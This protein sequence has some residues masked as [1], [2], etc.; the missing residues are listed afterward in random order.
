LI[1][2]GSHAA[3]VAAD[4][5]DLEQIEAARNRAINPHLRYADAR[6]IGFGLAHVDG[7]AFTG[8]LVHVKRSFE[9]LGTESPGIVGTAT[10]VV[11]RVESV[12]DATLPEPTLT[13]KK[14]FPL[15]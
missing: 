1:R 15:T 7:D 2:Y 5:H 14:P 9:P 4:T 10:F 6:G 11:P 13:G 12:T 3:N 8:T